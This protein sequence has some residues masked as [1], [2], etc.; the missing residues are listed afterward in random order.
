MLRVRAPN[1][2]SKFITYFCS[3]AS[4]PVI[5]TVN[6]DLIRKRVKRLTGALELKL[7]VETNFANAQ[8]TLIVPSLL[9]NA[10]QKSSD[11]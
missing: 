6:I 2:S 1:P 8:L 10:E 5:E 7:N 3:Q 9:C 11:N 4:I